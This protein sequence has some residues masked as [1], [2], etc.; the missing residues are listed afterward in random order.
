MGNW[1]APE[2]GNKNGAPSRR[3]RPVSA[4]AVQR[5]ATEGLSN[6]GLQGVSPGSPCSSR[7]WAAPCSTTR[8]PAR[9]TRSAGPGRVARSVAASSTR[10][11]DG[12][13]LLG[14][15]HPPRRRGRHAQQ[16]GS[17]RGV[18]DRQGHLLPRGQVRPVS[19]EG[20]KLL[21][22]E[23]THVVQQRDAPPAQE[24]RVSD[25]HEASEH[26]ASSVADA[27]TSPTSPAS[28]GAASVRSQIRGEGRR[29]REGGGRE[30]GGDDRRRRRTRSLTGCPRDDTREARRKTAAGRC[31]RGA[32]HARRSATG[33]WGGPVRERLVPAWP[34]IARAGAA[35]RGDGRRGGGGGRRGGGEGEVR[36]GWGF[37]VGEGGRVALR[38]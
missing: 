13:R 3:S 35:K 18:H 12:P 16:A 15:E 32:P 29:R 11:F 38:G 7:G 23:L 33:A 9:S 20:Q 27:V 34:D 37:R 4:A 14:R 36:E 21:A 5:S 30:G 8:S 26:E 22:H 10:R 31:A 19:N 28:A 25:P 1:H 24:L 6:K 2:E 17:G